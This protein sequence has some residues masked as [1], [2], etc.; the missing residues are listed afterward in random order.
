VPMTRPIIRADKHYRRK[1]L[2][3]YVFVVCLGG[4]V[5]GWG[6]PW[7]ERVLREQDPKTLFSVIRATLFVMLLSLAAPGV[8]F[9][10]LGRRI[11][12]EERFPLPNQKV[13]KDTR[14]LE[15]REA[16]I[17]GRVLVFLALILVFFG[18]FGAFYSQHL[19]DEFSRDWNTPENRN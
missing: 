12:E 14:L 6:L 5:I 3:L 9:L 11:M 7:A 15:G 10:R 19:L 16:R 2:L 18:V 13:L 17:R 1:M 8:Y 4:I